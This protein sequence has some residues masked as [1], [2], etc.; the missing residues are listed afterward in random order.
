MQNVDLVFKA[1]LGL[2]LGVKGGPWGCFGTPGRPKNLD[3]I[4]AGVEHIV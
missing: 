1:L 3:G 4:F 2:K